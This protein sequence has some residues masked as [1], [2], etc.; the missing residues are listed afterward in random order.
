M[1]PLYW[2]RRLRARKLVPRVVLDDPA[3]RET[4]F[5]IEQIGPLVDNFA[6]EG[7][8]GAPWSTD[9]A[10]ADICFLYMQLADELL[11]ELA[12][13]AGGY[14]AAGRI[15]QD[16]YTADVTERPLRR[17]SLAHLV[18]AGVDPDAHSTKFGMTLGALFGVLESLARTIDERLARADESVAHAARLFLHHCFQTFLDEV[19]LCREAPGGRADKLPLRK[20]AWHFYRKNN[21]VMMLWLDLRAR[22]LGL[23]PH[24][25]AGAIRR[26]GYLLASLQIFDDLKDIALDLERQPSY[27]LQIAANDF[28]EELD[29]FEARFG[30]R[31]APVTRDDVPEVSVHACNT[32]RHCMRWSRLVALAHFDNTLAYA[33]DQRWRKSW[34]RRRGSFNPVAESPAP[35]SGRPVD[36]L[37]RALSAL[38]TAGSSSFDDDQLAYALDAASYDGSRRILVALFPNLR[39]MYRF[40]T[41]QMW[42]TAAE[43]AA[44]ARRILG[45]SRRARSLALVELAD[46]DVDHE[47]SG[48]RLEP[49]AEQVDVQVLGRAEPGTRFE[50]RIS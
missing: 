16:L 20:T 8:A 15:V 23:A 46:G 47:V 1:L 42:M 11:D 29:W 28:P 41:L 27:P 19:E 36:A 9:A 43:K 45:R 32:V 7:K 48:D 22:I 25:H 24:E 26:W 14:A 4:F 12:A 37:L 18:G 10:L 21:L 40:A 33:W 30:N 50:Q 2:L 17:L 3:L 13:A 39:A 6:F 49:L 38:R 5:A 34:T 31:R 44:A 35:K